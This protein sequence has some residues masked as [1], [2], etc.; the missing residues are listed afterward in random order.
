MDL[1]VGTLSILIMLAGLAGSLVPPLPGTTLIL[2]GALL[3][4]WLLPGTLSWLA[5]GLIAAVWFL[6]VF[7]DFG[8]TLLGL[9]LFGGGKWGLAGAT[10]GALIGLLFSMRAFFL[11]AVLGAVVAEKFFARRTTGDALRT[12]AGAALGFVFAAFARFGCALLMLGAYVGSVL[13]VLPRAS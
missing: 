7:A 13:A 10:G 5:V 8:F 6:S 3:Q 9:R 2:L 12:G 1:V 11:G 4:K